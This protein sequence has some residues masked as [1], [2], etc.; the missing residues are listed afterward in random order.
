MFVYMNIYKYTRIFI[1]MHIYVYMR[2]YILCFELGESKTKSFYFK[3][4]K[5]IGF[6]F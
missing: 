5:K 6:D 3:K 2:L 1:F 4:N